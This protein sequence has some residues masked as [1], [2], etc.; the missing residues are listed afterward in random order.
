MVAH[1]YGCCTLWDLHGEQRGWAHLGY[2]WLWSSKTRDFEG[3]WVHHNL[4]AV[5]SMLSNMRYLMSKEMKSF[6]RNMTEIIDHDFLVPKTY[7][8]R[9]RLIRE[10]TFRSKAAVEKKNTDKEEKPPSWSGM[11]RR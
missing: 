9:A 11:D 1:V 7:I 3:Q 2:L 10:L 4:A 6:V 5:S 8:R